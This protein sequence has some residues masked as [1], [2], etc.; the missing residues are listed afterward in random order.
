MVGR[1]DIMKLVSGLISRGHW[2]PVEAVRAAR[3]N[4]YPGV[5]VR[6]REGLQ[7]IAFQPGADDRIAA[8]YVVRNPDKLAGV[9]V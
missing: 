4:G 2:L 9:R 8:I 7:T 5:I 3:I 1:E 6:D